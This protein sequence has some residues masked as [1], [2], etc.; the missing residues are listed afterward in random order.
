MI[1]SR[2]TTMIKRAAKVKEVKTEKMRCLNSH[3]HLKFFHRDRRE[4]N[5]SRSWWAR[6]RMWMMN[7]TKGS[8]V[9]GSLT[10]ALIPSKSL[11]LNAGTR[12]TQ[13]SIRLTQ[14]RSDSATKERSSRNRRKSIVKRK[15]T[16]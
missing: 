4:D 7:S 2:G 9:M 16:R 11:I 5:A 10:R 1:R 6:P 3:H 14:T 13:T 15:L 12:L 8:L